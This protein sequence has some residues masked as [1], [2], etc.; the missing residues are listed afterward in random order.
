MRVAYRIARPINLEIDLTIA[1]FTV[2]LGSSGAGK[3]T[4]LRALA[5]LLPAAGEPYGGLPPQTRPIGYLP[6]GVLLFPHLSVWRNVAY[7][8]RERRSLKR[9]RAEALLDRVGLGGFAERAPRTLSGGQMQRVALARALA[10]EPELLLLDERTNALD[11]A[12]RDRVLDELRSL[13]EELQLPALVATHDRHL[14]TIGDR[15]AILAGHRIVQEGPP[16]ELFD[17]P[18][19]EAAA[20][21]A[22]FENILEAR[23][24][25]QSEAGAVVECGGTGLRV[26]A[27][28]WARTAPAG[29]AIRAADLRVRP[30]AAKPGK[31]ALNLTV[32]K[33]R[34]EGL[35]TRLQLRGALELEALL[36]LQTPPCFAPGDSV[37]VF[38][39][40]D[41][42]RLIELMQPTSR[43]IR[44]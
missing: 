2:L 24:V 6:Q 26:T 14:A 27:S 1:G 4:V 9:Q 5:G 43:G 8:I 44:N 16:D 32:A 22:G 33:L 19:S 12:T 30:Q 11:P 13:I 42:L 34:R 23:I 18:R 40:P 39:P 35:G 7:A 36:P 37:T 31:N 10:R 41:R 20:R 3:T 28:D 21:L 17:R 15:V 29:L 25:G 38:L